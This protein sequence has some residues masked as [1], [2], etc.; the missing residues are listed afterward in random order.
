MLISSDT[1]ICSSSA[2]DFPSVTSAFSSPHSI[3]FTNCQ[4]YPVPHLARRRRRIHSFFRRCLHTASVTY[5]NCPT[6]FDMGSGRFRWA[7]V[8]KQTIRQ[9]SCPIFIKHYRSAIMEQGR[10]PV[11][12]Q[13]SCCDVVFK[14]VTLVI[15]LFIAHFRQTFDR[16]W[17]R[18]SVHLAYVC[19]LSGYIQNQDMKTFVFAPHYCLA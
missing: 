8:M 18:S 11:S 7:S 17:L 3:T 19:A 4:C 6:T 14:P 1:A 15:A 10:D 12:L 5:I 2:P 16:K 9:C 13:V